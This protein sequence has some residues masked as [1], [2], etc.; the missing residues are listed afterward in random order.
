ML[1]EAAQPWVA[2]KVAAS[3][4]C[5]PNAPRPHLHHRLLILVFSSAI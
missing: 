5:S 1:A 3:M 2:A 4:N